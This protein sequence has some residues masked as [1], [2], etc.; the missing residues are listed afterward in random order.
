M[1]AKIVEFANLGA[2]LPNI[3][4]TF[5]ESEPSL[6]I[7]MGSFFYRALLFHFQYQYQDDYKDGK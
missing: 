1:M 7:R 5:A 3:Q 6:G 2:L 4:W